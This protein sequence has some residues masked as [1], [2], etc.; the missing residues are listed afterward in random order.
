VGAVRSSLNRPEP[1]FFEVII[2]DSSLADR[3]VELKGWRDGIRCPRC[4]SSIRDAGRQPFCSSP[5]C[6]HYKAG[7][8]V[9]NGQPVL[10]D[11]ASSIFDRAMYQVDSG[12]AL[13]RDVSRRSLGSRLHRLAFGINPVAVANCRKFLDLLKKNSDRPLV[14]VIGGGAIGSGAEQLYGDPS[15]EL[16]GTDVYASPHTVLVADAHRLPFEDGMFD[17]VWIQAVLEHVLEPET[18]VAQIHRVMRRPGWY[19]PRR[20]SCSRC[21]NVPTISRDLPGVVIAG[22]SGGLPKSVRGRSEALALP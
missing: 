7:F 11:F 3:L 12:S 4:L 21:T 14:L 19:M 8:P 10:I 22:C 16:I 17:G 2:L 6:S 18:M 9:V 5:A 15:I 13:H 1:H 20:R